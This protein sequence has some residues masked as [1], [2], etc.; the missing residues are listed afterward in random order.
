MER[1]CMRLFRTNKGICQMVIYTVRNI[2][3]IV[4]S[5]ISLSMTHGLFGCC[6]SSGDIPQLAKTTWLCFASLAVHVKYPFGYTELHDNPRGGVG[7]AGNQQP[8]RA[9]VHHIFALLCSAHLMLCPLY[10]L[11]SNC[12]TRKT[13]CLCRSTCTAR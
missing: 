3:W 12:L 10:D 13:A 7:W 4:L 1:R 8:L 9:F 5:S 6:I 2:S 11:V